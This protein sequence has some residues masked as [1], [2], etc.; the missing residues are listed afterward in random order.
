M[1]YQPGNG[2]AAANGRYNQRSLMDR[3]RGPFL[4][5]ALLT[6]SVA[7]GAYL[8]I[9]SQPHGAL[10]DLL[11]RAIPSAAPTINAISGTGVLLT[12]GT[13]PIP[14][15]MY[16][17]VL[18]HKT[19]WF[20][21][22]T[23]EFARQMADLRAAGAHPISIQDAFDHLKS[24]K[25]VPAHPI[26][27]TFDDCTLGEYTDA[28]PILERY[29]FPATFFVQTAY[30]G[31]VTGK[32]HMTWDQLKSAEATGLITVESHTVTHP[33]DL[34]LLSDDQL[35][36]EMQDSKTTLEQKMG[37]P[38]NF[39]A[40]PSGN[41]DSRVGK[42]A[43]NAGY[44]AAVTMDR[45]W[46]ASPAQ[47][48]FLPR[49]A[50]A[51]V[52]DVLDAWSGR[53]KI[54]PPLPG[55]MQIADVPITQ[56]SSDGVPCTV[57]WLAGGDLASESLN[58]R[59]TVGEMALDAGA[60]AALNGT[61]FADARVQS[62]GSAMVGPVLSSVG[63]IY[64]PDTPS[65]EA[66]I[67]GRPMVMVGEKLC[68]IL[69]FEPH[70]AHTREDLS[71]IMPD[72]K[73]AFLAG[74]WIVHAG[75][76]VDPDLMETWSS[77]D[78]ADPRHRAFVGID[79]SGRYMLGATQESV[80]T[81]TLSKALAKMGVK[82]A[83]LL[84]SGFSTS[85]I[86]QNR[87]LVSGH[88]RKDVPSRPVPHAL[89]LMGSIAPDAPPPPQDAPIAAG[90]GGMTTQEAMAGDSTVGTTQFI[91]HHHRKHVRRRR[92]K[93]SSGDVT[94]TAPVV[95]P[96]LGDNVQPPPPDAGLGG[97]GPGDTTH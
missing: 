86:W 52:A 9:R 59:R 48:F 40:Y 1:S 7:C 87:V 51:R 29:H 57:S 47:S 96:G 12:G 76:A 73:D 81:E 8:G 15:I 23:P 50:P 28:L 17:D 97:S 62:N 38:I 91:R 66:R 11:Q 10:S 61:F 60:L 78:A 79:G 22:T 80:S 54:E 94:G 31:T 35:A 90:Q 45:G 36:R 34:T 55:L 69:P 24:G 49:F 56:G 67:I 71:W 64:Q 77:K 6:L 25:P 85:L 74:G 18:R 32:H 20:D 43:Q 3:V 41:C 27:L 88:A 70:L 44:L 68:L 19:V 93:V 72:V 75:R 26:V 42:S 83:F 46:A 4:I 39:L 37:H 63:S 84:D 30:V 65:E 89:F 21:L 53:G 5:L 16:H 33:E 92:V 13:Q 2:R 14:I 58:T 82:E 95:A